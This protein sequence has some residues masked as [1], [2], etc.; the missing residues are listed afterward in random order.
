[1]PPQNLRLMS[2][3]PQWRQEFE[4]TKSSVLQAT[5]GWITDIEHI[6]STALSDG[7]ARPIVDVVAGISDMQGLNEAALLVEGLNYARVESP[8][9]CSEELTACLQR[10][11]SGEV[12][13]TVLIVKHEGSAWSRALR[14]RSWLADHL[15]DWQTLQSVKQDNFAAGCQA[16]AKYSAAKDAFFEE[17]ETRIHFSA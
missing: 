4:Q 16:L 14:I 8:D 17:L 12:T 11:R 10:P 7:I 3:N 9:W 15:A 2:Y 5:E 6:G 13:H 1:M